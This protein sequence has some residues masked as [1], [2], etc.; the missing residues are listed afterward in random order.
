MSSPETH[1]SLPISSLDVDAD[2]RVLE[3]VAMCALNLPLTMRLQMDKDGYIGA[4][5]PISRLCN[6]PDHAHRFK[7]FNPA[8]LPDC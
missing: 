3:M 2:H 7:T 1:S 5:T 8:I 6:A 4:I